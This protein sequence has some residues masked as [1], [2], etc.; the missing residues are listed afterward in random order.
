MLLLIQHN[1][2][3]KRTCSHVSPPIPGLPGHDGTPGHDG[4]PGLNGIPGRDGP[5][6]PPG[7]CLVRD[8]A[9]CTRILEVDL[10]SGYYNISSPSETTLNWNVYPNSPAGTCT[11]QGVMTATFP[12]PRQGRQ[13]CRLKFVFHFQSNRTD[14][15]FDIG[16]SPPA[17]G[18][19]GDA[20]TTSNAAEVHGVNNHT[21]VFTGTLPGY[22]D[23]TIDG[24]LLVESNILLTNVVIITIGDELV[25]IDN[26][27]GVQRH[28]E[29]PY[30]F[31]LNGQA[32]TYG[33]IDKITK[34][35]SV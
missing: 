26:H 17:N 27:R 3:T 20:D 23:Y 11:R 28:Y 31:T 22:R 10:T 7:S 35:T 29:S 2:A 1:R 30:L 24:H 15:T 34:S 14:V 12:Q 18:Y 5:P 25:E 19:G 4:V 32:T 21:Y 33:P 9:N 13:P 16:D 6:G 8:C